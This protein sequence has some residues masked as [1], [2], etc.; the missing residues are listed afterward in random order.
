MTWE[1]GEEGVPALPAVAARCPALSDPVL[2]S[3]DGGI[4]DPPPACGPP[5]LPP[6]QGPGSRCNRLHF[7]KRYNERCDSMMERRRPGTGR[8]VGGG[9][10]DPTPGGPQ[11]GGDQGGAK[12]QA[13]CCSL[14]SVPNE[15]RAVLHKDRA[16]E[17]CGSQSTGPHKRAEKFQ[18]S[19]LVGNSRATEH[20][21]VLSWL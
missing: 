15:G 4:H 1:V 7:Q 8:G 13:R 19:V 11:G 20:T 17:A 18:Q 12:S 21:G 2:R 3:M 10:W 16:H 6:T 9:G 14:S 5:R